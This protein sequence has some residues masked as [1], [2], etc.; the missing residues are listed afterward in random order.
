[1]TRHHANKLPKTKVINGALCLGQ[2]PPFSCIKGKKEMK[3]GDY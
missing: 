3:Q 1:M 2:I